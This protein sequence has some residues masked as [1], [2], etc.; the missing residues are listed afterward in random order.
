MLFK[1]NEV[2]FLF[3][4]DG[5]QAVLVKALPEPGFFER[6]IIREALKLCMPGEKQAFSRSHAFFFDWGSGT[7]LLVLFFA[8]E[9]PRHTWP[10]SEVGDVTNAAFF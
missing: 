7:V 2:V 3:L 8:S 4:L 5:R 10:G 9:L 1:S 6:G